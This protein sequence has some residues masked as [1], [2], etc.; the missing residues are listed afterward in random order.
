[1]LWRVLQCHRHCSQPPMQLHTQ[2][3]QRHPL[4]GDGKHYTGNGYFDKLPYE[5]RGYR[6][7]NGTHTH[8]HTHTHTYTLLHTQQAPHWQSLNQTATQRHTHTHTYTLLYTQQAQH[9][10]WLLQLAAQ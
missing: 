4:A 6:F 10:Q 5:V 2:R 7:E 3:S 9:W 1:A 8:T